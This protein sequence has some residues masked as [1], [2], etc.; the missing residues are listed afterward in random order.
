MTLF[1]LENE[2]F[3]GRRPGCYNDPDFR[4]LEAKDPQGTLQSYARF[5]VTR[6]MSTSEAD[7]V[8]AAVPHVVSTLL[9]RASRTEIARNCYAASMACLQTLEAN[10]IWGFVLTGSVRFRFPLGSGLREQCLPALADLWVPDG[11]R[12]FLQAVG[13]VSRPDPASGSG[14]WIRLPNLAAVAGAVDP[15]EPGPRRRVAP[16]VSGPA[17]LHKSTALCGVCIKPPTDL[18]GE[19]SLQRGTRP[20]KPFMAAPWELPFLARDRRWSRR[21]EQRGHQ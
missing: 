11:P 17:W 20:Q 4:A 14:L 2:F 9:D 12:T 1:P 8:R 3:A 21:R 6:A 10:G 18:P 7:Y 5:V 13:G 19:P 15:V 16:T